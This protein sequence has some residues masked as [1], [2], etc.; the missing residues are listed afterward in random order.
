MI[1]SPV[2]FETNIENNFLVK[3]KS[4]KNF[5][6][7]DFKNLVKNTIM[8]EISKQKTPMF[9]WRFFVVITTFRYIPS[10]PEDLPI[11]VITQRKPIKER[12][13]S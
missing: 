10:N 1:F 13:V 12:D 6:A 5:F 7:Y 11:A 8:Y 4:T 3:Q 2:K 9:Y